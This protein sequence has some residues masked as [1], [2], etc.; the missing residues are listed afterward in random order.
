MWSTGTFGNHSAN[1]HLQ[2]DGNLVIYDVRA[3]GCKLSNWALWASDTS[4]PAQRYDYWWTRGEKLIEECGGFYQHSKGHPNK[5][6][7]EQFILRMNCEGE[8]KKL[9]LLASTDQDRK[10]GFRNWKV[11]KSYELDRAGKDA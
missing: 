9:E 2:D 1:L 4:L 10:D 6:Q 3:G 11:Y 8:N 7:D 5:G